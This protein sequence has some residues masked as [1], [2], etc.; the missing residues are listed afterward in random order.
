MESDIEGPRPPLHVTLTRAK[1]RMENNTHAT[2]RRPRPAYIAGSGPLSSTMD[3]RYTGTHTVLY[4][5]ALLPHG[6]RCAGI[7]GVLPGR[8]V[9]V[10]LIEAGE[11]VADP[12]HGD[13]KCG[14][15]RCGARY[16]VAQISQTMAA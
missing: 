3:A 7:L 6:G 10:R 15:K 1:L 8:W 9:K 4:C 5:H 11:R 13:L 12:T 16:A 14:D 2:Q